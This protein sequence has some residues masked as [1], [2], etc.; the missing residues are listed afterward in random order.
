MRADFDS[1]AGRLGFGITN[2]I[3]PGNLANFTVTILSKICDISFYF[4]ASNPVVATRIL[5]SYNLSF[6]YMYTQGIKDMLSHDGACM[7]CVTRKR[8]FC[9][10][11]NNRFIDSTSPLFPKF[12]F[13]SF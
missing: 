10:C 4:Y 2:S 13:L 8:V 9:I 6:N 5:L 3:G 1:R 7:S 12:E 11:E